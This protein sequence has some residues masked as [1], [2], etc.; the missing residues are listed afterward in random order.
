MSS[1]TPRTSTVTP[2][3]AGEA[4]CATTRKSNEIA[5]RRVRWLLCNVGMSPLYGRKKMGI[6][7]RVAGLRAGSAPPLRTASSRGGVQRVFRF[8]GRIAVGI[9]AALRKG[10]RVVAGQRQYRRAT[11]PIGRI[12]YEGRRQ[13]ARPLRGQVGRWGHRGGD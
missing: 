7:M 9:K 10:E 8:A 4:S 12:E 2:E 1:S 11:G 6:L 3:K 13:L 5:G